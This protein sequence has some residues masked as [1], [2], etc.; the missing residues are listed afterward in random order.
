MP[1]TASLPSGQHKLTQCDSSTQ[2]EKNFILQKTIQT[3][4][5]A[6]GP[7]GKERRSELTCEQEPRTE[8]ATRKETGR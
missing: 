1:Q 6:Q 7:E 8:D 5:P 3:W 2:Q 4:T